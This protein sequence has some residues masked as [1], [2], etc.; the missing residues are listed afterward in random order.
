MS[1]ERRIGFSTFKNQYG[2]KI[3]C[4]NLVVQLVGTLG[5]AKRLA[6]LRTDFDM[7]SDRLLIAGLVALFVCIAVIG[8]GQYL[9]LF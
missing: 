7:T 9:Q 8:V 2:P 4:K 3:G 5:R 1:E 6:P